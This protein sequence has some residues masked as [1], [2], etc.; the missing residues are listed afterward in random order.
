MQLFQLREGE[1]LPKRQLV[2]CSVPFWPSLPATTK[3]QDSISN[4]R[5]DRES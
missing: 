1:S 5:K 3:R 2:D 4:M